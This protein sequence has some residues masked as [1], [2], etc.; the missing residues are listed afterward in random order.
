MP[1]RALLGWFTPGQFHG[2][3]GAAW[4]NGAAA[5]DPQW[6][7]GTAGRTFTRLSG[8]ADALIKAILRRSHRLGEQR[9]CLP[10]II[11]TYRWDYLRT[12][13]TFRHFRMTEPA[14]ASTQA[15]P[16]RPFISG[17][18]DARLDSSINW[19]PGTGVLTLAP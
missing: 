17:V 4:R 15:L 7:A 9:V 2:L 18:A 12:P 1:P 11:P 8:S 14:L 6:T 16:G 3:P 5:L 13:S 10:E 19:N